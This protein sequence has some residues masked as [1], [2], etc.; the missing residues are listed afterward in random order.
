MWFV[1]GDT[2]RHYEFPYGDFDKVHRCGIISAESRSGQYK[3]FDVE[4]A[5]ADLFAM[6]DARSGE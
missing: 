1:R 5:A 3:H 4:K 2:Q 6:I